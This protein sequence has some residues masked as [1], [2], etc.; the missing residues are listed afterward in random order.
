LFPPPLLERPISVSIEVK[1]P[2]VDFVKL[3]IHCGVW[4]TAQFNRLDQLVLCVREAHSVQR[5]EER[6]H[7]QLQLQLQQQQ[8]HEQQLQQQQQLLPQWQRQKRQQQQKQHEQQG[9][10]QLPLLSP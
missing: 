8:Q 7:L 10:Q 3:Q 6:Q 5:Q 1:S 9:Q 4:V 2:G